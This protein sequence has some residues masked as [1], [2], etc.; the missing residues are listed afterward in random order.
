MNTDKTVQEAAEIAAQQ[1]YPM[2]EGPMSFKQKEKND[3]EAIKQ[4]CFIKGFLA[5]HSLANEQRDKRI[6]ELE[7]A[8]REIDE[9]TQTEYWKDSDTMKEIHRVIE[10]VFINKTEK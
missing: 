10:P 1:E 8:L 4:Y 3:E 7:E 2:K 6:A 9:F 5:G